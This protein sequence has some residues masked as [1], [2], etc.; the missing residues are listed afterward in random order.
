MKRLLFFGSLAVVVAAVGFG[1]GWLAATSRPVPTQPPP[2]PPTPTA[3]EASLKAHALWGMTLG[4]KR[5][6]VAENETETMTVEEIRIE[7]ERAIYKLM[8]VDERGNTRAEDVFQ[9]AEGVW[10]YR[11]IN[12]DGE[13]ILEHHLKLPCKVGEQWP[14]NQL[15]AFGPVPHTCD[16]V[17]TISVPAGTFQTIKVTVRFDHWTGTQVRS[18]WYNVEHGLIQYRISVSSFVAT[19]RNPTFKLTSRE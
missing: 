8:T 6:Y 15:G 4:S 9:N 1:G 5:V 17:E 10:H 7:K 19:L 13:E 2:E 14:S 3:A 12:L 16:A 18:Y 11:D